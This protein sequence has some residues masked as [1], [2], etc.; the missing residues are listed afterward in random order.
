MV[1]HHARVIWTVL[2]LFALVSVHS[3]WAGPPTDQL[4]EGVDRVI[5][6]LRDP[7]LMG[8]KK[9][10]RAPGRHQQGRRRDLRLHGDGEAGPRAA[11]GPANARRARGVRPPLHRA[12]PAHVYRQ[13]GPVQLPR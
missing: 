7:E 6:I 4:R 9:I 2:L 13:G 5:K 1:T 12:G 11:L 3:A 10:E 8:D